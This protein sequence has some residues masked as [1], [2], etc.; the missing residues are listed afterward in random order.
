MKKIFIITGRTGVG[1]STLCEKLE[2][3]F[4]YPLLSFA[5]MGKSFASNNGYKRIRD[6]HLSM[7]L[8]EFKTKISAH[9]FD[10]IDKQMNTYNNVIIDGLYIEDTLKRLKEKYDCYVVYLRVDDMVRYERIS[11]RLSITLE[12]AKKENEIKERLKD[13]VGIDTFIQDADFVIDGSKSV[14]EVFE[15]AKKYIKERSFYEK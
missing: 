6:C 3:Y 7:D 15:I 12:D 2:Q 11:N 9:I 14:Q 10:I 8:N 1:K 13:E 5:G 4:H